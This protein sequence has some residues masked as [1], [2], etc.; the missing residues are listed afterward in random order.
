MD[1]VATFI[2][3][4]VLAE[5]P[6]TL[7]VTVR[8]EIGPAAFALQEMF[9]IDADGQPSSDA[10]PVEIPRLA[11]SVQQG[12][13]VDSNVVTFPV[14]T[15]LTVRNAVG[16][17]LLFAQRAATAQVPDKEQTE[18]WADAY[19]GVLLATGW[20]ERESAS[21]WTEEGAFGSKVYEKVLQLATVVLG[22]VPTALAIVTAALTS[23][24]SM[25]EDSPWITL[26]D[27]R[28]KSATAVGFQIANC[29][30]GVEGGAALR[31]VDFRVHAAQSMTQVLFFKFTSREARM[32]KR[33]VVLELTEHALRTYGPKIEERVADITLANIAAFDLAGPA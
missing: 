3:Q 6:D 30:A 16:N 24:Q 14:D 20:A 28:G 17:W 22:P 19:L 8:R 32:F 23:L 27:R 11:D 10:A 21:A 15:P 12:A 18:A 2:Q 7:G 25:N 29:E 4:T 26:F 5:I 31:A 13:V 9:P 33:G 1:T